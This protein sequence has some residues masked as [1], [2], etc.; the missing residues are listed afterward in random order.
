MPNR[1]EDEEGDEAATEVAARKEGYRK[2]G[3]QGE[4]GAKHLYLSELFIS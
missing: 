4:G 2:E 3:V 1:K